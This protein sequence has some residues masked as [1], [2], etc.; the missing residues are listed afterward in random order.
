M[1]LIR[2]DVG[3]WQKMPTSDPPEPVKE[4]KRLNPDITPEMAAN[5]I[6][7]QLSAGIYSGSKGEGLVRW[8]IQDGSV[9]DMLNGK[10]HS[11]IEWKKSNPN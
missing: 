4:R 11:I 10:L 8:F 9:V 5:L 7:V 3:T 2:K 6:P 1:K